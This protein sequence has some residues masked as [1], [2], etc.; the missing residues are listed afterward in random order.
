M[1]LLLKCFHQKTQNVHKLISSTVYKK[2]PKN[3]LEMRVLSAVI[4][5][6]KTFQK[7]LYGYFTKNLY[8]EKDGF[9]I[10]RMNKKRVRKLKDRGKD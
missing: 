5:F 7:C 4:N 9:C 1:R 2:C 3:I 8:L 6:T 10:Q